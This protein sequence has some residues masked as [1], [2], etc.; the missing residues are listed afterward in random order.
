MSKTAEKIKRWR[1]LWKNR[2]A[3]AQTLRDLGLL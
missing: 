2:K 3:V 1:W